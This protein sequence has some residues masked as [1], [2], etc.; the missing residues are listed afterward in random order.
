MCARRRRRAGGG[1]RL[2]FGLISGR[3]VIRRGRVAAVLGG[4]SARHGDGWDET[5]GDAFRDGAAWEDGFGKPRAGKKKAAKKARKKY[6]KRQGGK[7]R[8]RTAGG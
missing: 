5:G 7:F 6:P 2:R 8:A 1:A 4:T 3:G